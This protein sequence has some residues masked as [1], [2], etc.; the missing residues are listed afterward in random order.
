MKSSD[1]NN[2]TKSLTL[3]TQRVA[4]YVNGFT[5]TMKEEYEQL[6]DSLN[7]N[8][9][10]EAGFGDWAQITFLGLNEPRYIS[11]FSDLDPNKRYRTFKVAKLR[12]DDEFAVF[13][14]YCK[15]LALAVVFSGVGI[16]F[17]GVADIISAIG[18]LF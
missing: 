11:T 12:Y 1:E 7:H 18:T 13:V 15:L 17:M 3:P 16:L 9:A 10:R 4:R 8:R 2:E 5:I 6:L 14:K